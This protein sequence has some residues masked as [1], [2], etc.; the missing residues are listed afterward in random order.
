VSGPGA[1]DASAARGR[2][3]RL[4]WCAFAFQTAVCVG[5]GVYCVHLLSLA[6]PDPPQAQQAQISDGPGAATFMTAPENA[7]NSA[8]GA[9][10]SP[11][12]ADPPAGVKEPPPATAQAAKTP[13]QFAAKADKEMPLVDDPPALAAEKPPR[14]PEVVTPG[15]QKADNVTTAPVWVD[16]AKGPFCRGDLEVTLKV[17]FHDS[18]GY[19]TATGGSKNLLKVC[20]LVVLEIANSHP[21]QLRPFTSWQK[22]GGATLKD[23]HGNSYAQVLPQGAVQMGIFSEQNYFQ[24]TGSDISPERKVQDLL[25]FRAPVKQAEHL[26]LELPAANVGG[27]EPIRLHLTRAI[28]DRKLNAP[29]PIIRPEVKMQGVLG[30]GGK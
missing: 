11:A 29:G 3:N 28:F 30:G 18:P 1:R 22:S 16:A 24:F 10:Q 6:K 13:P 21:T 2:P 23:E 27:G 19:F 15:P 8:A 14:P 12:A 9:G 7:S 17:A 5:L 20:Q 25:V 26:Y 4:L